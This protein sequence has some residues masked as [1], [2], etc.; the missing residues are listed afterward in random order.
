[1]K[2]WFIYFAGNEA[3]VNHAKDDGY[4]V[5]G[6]RRLVLLEPMAARGR[7]SGRGPQAQRSGRDEQSQ[8]AKGSRNSR[9]L[10]PPA[11]GAFAEKTVFLRR[12]FFDDLRKIVFSAVYRGLGLRG[13][14]AI[15][16]GEDNQTKGN[17][18]KDD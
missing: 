6:K 9:R 16:A 5:G 8:T 12:R 10:F 2:C 17:E 15:F 7:M 1:M 11:Q 4:R 13:E 14:M 3:V 18:S